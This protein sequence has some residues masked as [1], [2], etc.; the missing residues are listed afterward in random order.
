MKENTL[1]DEE[2]RR[3]E[4]RLDTPAVTAY[5][6]ELRAANE[7]DEVCK[8]RDSDSERFYHSMECA[9]QKIRHT[10]PERKEIEADGGA[11]EGIADLILWHYEFDGTTIP[12][13]QESDD[14]YALMFKTITEAVAA[15]G[16]EYRTTFMRQVANV[17]NG[18][19]KMSD[20]SGKIHYQFMPV[21]AAM[22][23]QVHT[24]EEI[25]F[26][27]HSAGEKR[28]HIGSQYSAKVMEYDP[29][30]IP[31]GEPT[32]EALA[33]LLSKVTPE[34]A[35]TIFLE[36]FPQVQGMRP[37]SSK[38]TTKVSFYLGNGQGVES[39]T[40][41]VWGRTDLST[42]EEKLLYHIGCGLGSEGIVARTYFGRKLGIRG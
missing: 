35:A 14:P 40:N 39:V 23:T 32:K 42:K 27:M 18:D 37:D 16:D 31:D 13:F 19:I 1:S 12:M 21:I 25:E 20:R 22:M 3:L 38:K 11:F 29:D 17:I 33:E 4:E 2:R 8:L 7:L 15:V 10:Q 24:S 41:I 9:L 28:A 26:I 30:K 5:V 36:R 6:D 34:K